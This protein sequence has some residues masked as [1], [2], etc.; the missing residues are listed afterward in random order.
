MFLRTP[1][2]PKINIEDGDT[3]VN[4][5]WPLHDYINLPLS[6]SRWYGR[7]GNNIQQIC[8]GL[9]YARTNGYSF[10]TRKHKLIDRIYYQC[11]PAAR[12][13]PQARNRFMFYHNQH[14]PWF[15]VELFSD[16]IF[17]EIQDVAQEY[18]LP[19]FS[20]PVGEPLPDDV[21]V[22]HARGG[23]IMKPGP[24][25]YWG[26][27]QNPLSYY[28]MLVPHF[29]QTIL[30]AEP[31][32]DNPIIGELTKNPRVILQSSSVQEDFATML[33]ARNL[34]ASG[35]GTFAVA[36]GLCSRNLRQ[37]YSSDRLLV[38]GLSPLMIKSAA[39]QII[40]LGDDYPQIGQWNNNDPETKVK[41]LSHSVPDQK[42]QMFR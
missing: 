12:F 32:D 30:V 22:V 24:T 14:S 6:N 11:G 5:L 2:H 38:G 25:T 8:V 15:D 41:M 29:R 37:F 18:V 28:Q 7:L 27:V 23:D 36:A 40:S 39:V 21:L 26:N 34:A 35:V 16:Q 3:S 20:F 42:V 17:S 13:L 31:G 9:I 4:R 1:R 19:A 33:R 10:F